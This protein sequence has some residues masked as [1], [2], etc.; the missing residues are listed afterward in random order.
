MPRPNSTRPIFWS[1][2]F[3]LTVEAGLGARADQPPSALAITSPLEGAV[4]PRDIAPPLFRWSVNA[5]DARWRVVVDLAGSGGS[6]SAGCA[7][8]EWRPSTDQWERIKRY[9]LAADARFSVS[10][11]P[12][13]A[14]EGAPAAVVHFRTS[15][16]PVGAPIFYREV[17]LPV[18]VAMDNKPKISWRVGDISSTEPPRTVLTGMRTCANCHSFT[19]D[20]KTLAMDLDF[21]T[22]KGA[23]AI[24]PIGQ[25]VK[26]GR[27]ELITWNDYRREDGQETLG[28]SSTISPDGR[29]VVSTV[30]ETIVL[31]FLPNPDC[32]QIFFPIRGILAF[33]DR[34]THDFKSLHGADNPAYVQTNSTFSPDGRWLVFARAKVPDFIPQGLAVEEGLSPAIVDEF[35]DG[36]RKIQF[37]LY[38]L[39]FN[40]GRGG[41]AEPVAGASANGRSNFFARFSPDGRWLVFCQAESMMLNRLDSDLFIM[42][43]AGGTPRRLRCNAQGRMNSWHSFSPN[44]HWLVYASKANGPFTQLWLTHIDEKGNDTPPVMLDRFVTPERAANIPEFVNLAPGQLTAINIAEEIRQS[45]S[46]LPR[47]PQ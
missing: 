38:R 21:G 18:S 24:A 22:D 37:D 41:P 11:L 10:A 20:G 7:G 5:P 47:R 23:Y 45:T 15:P 46:T 3:A 39:P 6:I 42:P 36:R 1:A 19:P 16:D 35:A 32:S 31:K 26:I 13:R 12:V 27:S 28:F 17:P 9:S 14:G 30:K 33:Y 4:F 40:D 2:L 8:L 34:Q 25:E 44:G 43:A 29:K